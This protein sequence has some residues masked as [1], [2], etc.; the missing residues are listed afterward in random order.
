MPE[1]S[2]VISGPTESVT[3]DPDPQEVFSGDLVSWSNRTDYLPDDAN[4]QTITID[5]A[6]PNVT[7]PMVAP[8]WGSSSPAYKVTQA[9]GSTVAYTVKPT[10]D[11]NVAGVKGTIKVVTALALLLLASICAPSLHAQMKAQQDC[12]VLLGGELQDPPQIDRDSGAHQLRGTLST[13]GEKELIA[14]NKGTWVSG[15]LTKDNITCV[16][17]WV[18]TYRKG[19]GMDANQNPDAPATLPAPGPTLRSQIGDLVELTFLNLIDPLNFPGTDT[20]K[21]DETQSSAGAVYPQTDTYPNCFHGSVFTNV[22]F[23]G[24][25]TSPNSTADNVFLQIVPSPRS[26]NN[27]RTPFVTAATVQNAFKDFFGRCEQMLNLNNSPQQWPHIYADLP[28]AF[29]KTQDDLLSKNQPKLYAANLSAQANGAF[30]Q[31]YIGAFPYC[32]RLPVYTDAVFPPAP[33]TDEMATHMAGAGSTEHDETL[34]PKRKLMMGQAPGTHWYHA[35]KHGST[36]LN[37][38][39]GMSGVMVI[40]GKYDEEIRDYYKGMGGITEHVILLN[41]IGVTPR[42]EGGSAPSPGPYFSA[43]GRLQPVIKMKP[44]EVQWWRIADASSRSG[45]IL[46]TPPADGLTRRQLAV[47]GVQFANA[48]YVESEN[49]EIVLTSGSR[50]DLLVM[51]PKNATGRYPVMATLTTDPIIDRANSQVLFYVE[52][53]TSGSRDMDFMNRASSYFPPYLADITKDE[54]T[55]HKTITFATDRDPNK[56]NFTNHTINGIKFSGEVGALVLLNQTEEWKIENASYNP[57]IAHPFHIHINPFQITEEFEPNAR[58]ST[59][60]GPGTV[61]TVKDSNVVTGTGFNTTFRVGD[62]ITIAGESVA[63]V[64]SIAADGTSLVFSTAKAKGVT[65]AA[66]T[67]GIPLYTTNKDRQDQ[68]PDQCYIDPNDNTSWHPCGPTEPA[69]GDGRKWWDVFSIP[70]GQIF[71]TKGSTAATPIPG[72]FKLVSRFVDYS[73]YYVI[74]CHILAHEDRGMMTV[75]YVAPLQPPFSHH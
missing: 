23:H 2:I 3:L 46:T 62:F 55:G 49:K 21:C 69:E 72:Y 64:V 11:P 38:S 36:T 67:V 29:R 44:G 66:Y 22:H 17:Q 70:S 7:K 47:D 34:A 13:V 24:T 6:D 35:H 58:L 60:N 61:S 32:Y 37:L 52:I 50:A 5:G 26:S 8:S 71:Y 43:N 4:S 10:N 54:V 53:D 33:M 63:N 25:H 27:A 14:F 45:L 19:D 9:A 51:A 75:V 30:P 15:A 39:N 56:P 42:R 48:R 68:H 1:W 18:R 16:P 57:K 74:H 65:N 41:Q 59:T 31:N 20:G 12:S 73:G 40:E 28:E